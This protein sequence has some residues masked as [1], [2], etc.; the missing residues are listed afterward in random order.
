MI[1]NLEQTRAISYTKDEFENLS[2]SYY[3]LKDEY[4]YE[5]I[6]KNFFESNK[7]R[8]ETIRNWTKEDTD[9]V[10]KHRLKKGLPKIDLTEEIN[11]N[12]VKPI[13]VGLSL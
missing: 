3:L 6:E 2:C 7:D 10:N 1:C 8:I 13:R 4:S 9:R 5:E 11:Y 12:K